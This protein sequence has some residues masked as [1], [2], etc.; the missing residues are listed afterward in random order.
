MNVGE[1]RDLLSDFPDDLL[2][3]MSEGAWGYTDVTWVD[4]DDGI[5]HRDSDTEIDAVVIGG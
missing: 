3:L 2:V 1:L 5:T 4:R